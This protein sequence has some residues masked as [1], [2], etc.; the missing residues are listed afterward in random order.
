VLFD[1]MR[2]RFAHGSGFRIGM[3]NQSAQ[4][5]RDL[6]EIINRLW[7]ETTQGGRLY[8]AAL[9]REVLVIG[10]SPGWATGEVGSSLTVMRGDQ[11]NEHD[12]PDGWT[13]LVV[14]GVA[15]D[16][17]LSEF[18]ARYELTTY[19]TDLLWGP[20]TREQ[21]LVWLD[22]A[23]PSVDQVTHLDRLFGVRRQGGKVY[24]PCRPEVLSA[25]PE[26]A[27]DGFW[28][29]VRAD[30]PND[31]FAHVRHIDAGQSCPELEFG[32]CPVEELAEGS[33]QDAVS[34]LETLN[35]KLQ[36]KAYLD[37][38]VP[39]RWSFPDSVGY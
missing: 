1:K 20:G 12:K 7:G 15:R 17:Q 30:F 38:H 32:G 24:I 39:R 5:I 27:H 19:P 13:Y 4:A 6:A 16:E 35:P 3:P 23:M 26:D 18:D 14:L 36:P 2:N 21:A 28:H 29:L 10:W 25:L 37:V 31:A 34:A 33:W 9:E 22:A 8:P 11:L